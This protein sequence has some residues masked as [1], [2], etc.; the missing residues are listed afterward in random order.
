[1]FSGI[2]RLQVCPL[3]NKHDQINSNG[4]DKLTKNGLNN[5][6]EELFDQLE[7]VVNDLED[8]KNE[9]SEIIKK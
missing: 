9:T 4:I 7:V 8:G 1:M 2:S 5:V 3:N 6:P